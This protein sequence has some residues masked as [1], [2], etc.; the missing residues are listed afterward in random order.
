MEEIAKALKVIKENVSNDKWKE[1]C[2]VL[3]D[4]NASKMKSSP[5][6]KNVSLSEP[7][8]D[9]QN[10]KRFNRRMNASI[11][12]PPAEYNMRNTPNVSKY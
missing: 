11:T 6:E 2:C 1:L 10:A 7:K 5:F 8:L 9:E 12:V 3:D 4:D